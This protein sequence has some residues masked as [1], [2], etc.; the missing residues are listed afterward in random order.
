[1][2]LLSF[3][4]FIVLAIAAIAAT[5]NTR[6]EEE[7]FQTWPREKATSYKAPEAK[8]PLLVGQQEEV[9][10]GAKQACIDLGRRMGEAMS[11]STKLIGIKKQINDG[12]I[13][14]E[15]ARQKLSG[16]GNLPGFTCNTTPSAYCNDFQ[17]TLA[18]LNTQLQPTSLTGRPTII[19]N[20]DGTVTKRYISTVSQDGSV[21]TF[22]TGPTIRMLN[23]WINQEF[24]KVNEFFRIIK[25][26][27]ISLRCDKLI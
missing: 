19:V 1:M 4:P 12:A 17:D 21:N 20:S 18:Y 23:N 13:S 16:I 6:G 15:E 5:V 11:V 25:T 27:S 26:L 7:G 10:T 22:S 14:L 9:E 2:R 24:E 8:P 3:I